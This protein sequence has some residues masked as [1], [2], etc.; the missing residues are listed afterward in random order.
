[1]LWENTLCKTIGD[2]AFLPGRFRTLRARGLSKAFR[3]WH[4]TKA[5]AWLGLRYLHNFRLPSL[6]VV[7]SWLVNGEVVQR[8]SLES[9]TQ[10]PQFFEWCCGT[11][12]HVSRGLPPVVIEEVKIDD[13]ENNL[14]ENSFEPVLNVDSAVRSHGRLSSDSSKTNCKSSLCSNATR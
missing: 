1:M 6:L 13:G 8:V 3:L 11:E 2:L 4:F 7:P 5:A 10:A 14:S 12:Q 9:S